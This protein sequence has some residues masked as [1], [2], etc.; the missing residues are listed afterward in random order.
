MSTRLNWVL[1]AVA[2]AVLVLVVVLL[3]RGCGDDGQ[4]NAALDAGG[5]ADAAARAAG[6]VYWVGPRAGA[7]YELDEQS[8][9]RFFV[10]YLEAG[11]GGT[12]TPS[13]TVGTYRS[14]HAAA[15]LRRSARRTPGASLART[16]DGAV[17]LVQRSAANNA[18][19]AYP[20][21]DHEIEVF[22]PVPGEALRLAARGAVR[23][24]P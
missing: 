9:G 23:P 5:L 10:R 12:K 11:Q 15:A 17:L 8:S 6:P 20:G 4:E 22:S 2:A 18:H 19:L 24:V 21:S 14:P 3:A 16:D 13:L 7:R 1:P